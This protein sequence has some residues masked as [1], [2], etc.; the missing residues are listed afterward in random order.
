M[1]RA[2]Q[3]RYPFMV[4]ITEESTSLE[5]NGVAA[6]HWHALPLLDPRPRTSN[7]TAISV[8]P[9]F[10][11]VVAYTPRTPFFTSGRHPENSILF[12]MAH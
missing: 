9:P 12:A 7:G 5:T 10:T 3:K 6:Q 11:S 4:A 1:W 2:S 8:S